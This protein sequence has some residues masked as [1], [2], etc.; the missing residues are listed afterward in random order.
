MN[1]LIR[2]IPH[3]KQ[4]Y[5]TVGDWEFSENGDLTITVS[6]MGNW[7]YE[8]L[9]ALHELVEVS[10]CKDRDIS[11][12]SVDSFDIQFEEERAAGLHTTEEEPGHDP[13]A[14]YKDEHVFAEIIERLLAKQLGVDWK[15]YDKTVTNL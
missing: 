8:L 6:E 11:Q 13:R 10:L 1:I 9:V 5:P 4:R 15:T 7:K 2:T 14:P 12:E 3:S